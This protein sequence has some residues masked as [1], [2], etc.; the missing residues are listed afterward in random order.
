M[1]ALPGSAGY[2]VEQWAR[3][4]VFIKMAWERVYTDRLN[5]E[6]VG[7]FNNTNKIIAIAAT[8]VVE[9]EIRTLNRARAI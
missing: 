8:R 6:V 9:P 7:V 5:L 3:N 1:A 2:T 4:A